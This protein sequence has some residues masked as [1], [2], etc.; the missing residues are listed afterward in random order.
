MKSLLEEV[1]REIMLPDNAR[2]ISGESIQ[3]W[4]EC[5]D[6]EVLGAVFKL[7]HKPEHYCRITPPLKFD[8]YRSFHLK[9][10]AR[11]IVENPDGT[12]TESRYLAAHSLVAWFKGLW[13]DPKIPRQ[14]LE[15]LKGMLARLYREGD[16]HIR[17]CIVTGSLEHL[18]ER[19]D[20]LK[21]FDDW[22]HDPLLS[23]PYTEARGYAA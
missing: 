9:Y 5:S 12:W 10:Y 14:A 15:E 8:D 20:I 23:E 1:T 7:L 11:C 6:L 21:F 17:T 4:I 2:V 19:R 22:K 18:F 3:R 16:E 13:D